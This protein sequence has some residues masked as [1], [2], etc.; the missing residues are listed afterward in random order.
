MQKQGFFQLSFDD[1]RYTLTSTLEIWDWSYNF[2]GDFLGMVIARV[3]KT[4]L[5]MF[6]IFYKRPCMFIDIFVL[7]KRP[8]LNYLKNQAISVLW[9]GVLLFTPIWTVLLNKLVQHL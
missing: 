7:Y 4:S 1:S 8:A 2:V 3:S 6:F 9:D 5:I